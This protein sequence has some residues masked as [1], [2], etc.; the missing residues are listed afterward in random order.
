MQLVGMG[1]F[2]DEKHR[3]TLIL[4]SVRSGFVYMVLARVQCHMLHIC[5]H[6]ELEEGYSVWVCNLIKKRQEQ[7]CQHT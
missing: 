4:G 7:A 2:G 6:T 3:H 5:K 1:A